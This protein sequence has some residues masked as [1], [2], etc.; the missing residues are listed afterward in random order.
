MFKIYTVFP[1]WFC[2]WVFRAVNML[3]DVVKKYGT[4]IYVNHEIIHNKFIISYFE[5]LGVIFEPNLENIPSG[6]IVVLSAH[7]VWPS[8]REKLKEKW[9]K[10]IDATCPLVEKVH[11]EAKMFIEKG[12]KILYIGQ[13]NHQEALW[14]YDYDTAQIHILSTKEDVDMLDVSFTDWKLALLTQTT[15]SVDDTKEVIDYII[16]K[17][18][19]VEI[20]KASDICYATTNRQNAVKELSKIIDTLFVVG[21]KNSS[22][23][24]KLKHLAEKLWKKAYLVDTYEDILDEYL[25]NAG[26]IWVASWAS[27][28]EELVQW[29]VKYLES[30]GGTFTE[31]L[32]VVEEKVTFPYTLELIN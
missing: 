32:R 7:W 31:E 2:A 20:P 17:F 18:P 10:Y 26:D 9:L 15:L 28:P 27:W 5:K 1:R 8:F 24:N 30:K 4:P 12:Y 21:S 23:S 13:K 29:V 19:H 11:R 6:S 3:Q 22:N 25:V 14:V 16:Q